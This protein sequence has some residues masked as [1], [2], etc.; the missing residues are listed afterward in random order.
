MRVLAA[1]LLILF[2]SAFD[3]ANLSAE[4]N[5]QKLSAK[6]E[7][8]VR[9]FAMRVAVNIEK[10]RDL[11]RY[12]NK[13]PASNFFDKAIVDSNDSD[14]MV[15]QNVGRK[16]GR[17]ELRRFYFVM[18]N[19]AYLSESYV[20]SKF[21]FEKTA[22]R[23]LLPQQQYPDHVVRILE[24]NPNLKQWWSK[25]FSDSETRITTV[26]Q[27][28]SLLKTYQNAVRLMRAY[29]GRHPPERT[30]IYKQNLAH[31]EDFLN[32]IGVDTCESEQD[33]AGLPLGTQTVR[34][35]LPVLQLSLVRLNGRLK[36]CSLVFMMTNGGTC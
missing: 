23:D 36:F 32:E 27:F 31:L 17:Y 11:T 35:N 6:E 5:N 8:E 34:V 1:L 22:V 15:D 30:A 26:V 7:Q 21:L 3:L 16:V 9:E 29:F 14:G 12:L 4:E 10:T 2:V 18:W 19:L 28:Y 13:P 20:F 24:R 33:C 25:N